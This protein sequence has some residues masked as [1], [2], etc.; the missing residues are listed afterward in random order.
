MSIATTPHFVWDVSPEIFRWGWLAP[1]WYGLLFGLGF[2]VGFIIVGQMFQREGKPERDLDVL[3][4]YLVGGT[5][6]GA[7]LGHVLFY[8]PTYYLLRPI[9]ILKVWEGGLASHGGALGVLAALG[10]YARRRDDQPYLWLLDRIAV[11]T[12]L[13]GGLIRLGNFFNSEILGQPA[14][15]A[16]AVVFAR[17]DEVPRHP[18]QLY[19]SLGYVLIFAG[20]LAIYR[21]RGPALPHGLLS[22]LFLTSVFSVRI[23]LEPFKVPQAAFADQLPLFSMGQWLSLPFVAVGLALIARAL[24]GTLYTRD[25]AADG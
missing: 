20:L 5:I 17:I 23:A 15:V 12:A 10:L 16:W 24:R 9:E 11:P 25:R 21:R 22:G 8:D 14:D 18:V 1:R 2:F 6:I 19:E 4:M 3:L 13:V 7:R